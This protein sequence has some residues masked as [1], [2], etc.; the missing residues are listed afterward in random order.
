MTVAWNTPAI[1]RGARI[2]T[3]RSA[4]VHSGGI[5]GSTASETRVSTNTGF[6]IAGIQPMWLAQP[7]QH[8]KCRNPS[9][10]ELGAPREPGIRPPPTR[11]THRQE[12]R[13][14]KPSLAAGACRSHGGRT[15]SSPAKH[16]ATR[17]PDLGGIVL[18][19]LSGGPAGSRG[20]RLVPAERRRF[21]WVLAAKK[22]RH[23]RAR[24]HSRHRRIPTLRP[25]RAPQFRLKTSR[26]EPDRNAS[27]SSR[28]RP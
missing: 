22:L 1:M 13:R 2:M 10:R 11:Q 20:P 23:P 27:S 18:C 21:A 9:T 28:L 15:Q 6:R 24:R 4:E 19:A 14:T 12:M 7:Q 8:T 5:F 17:A 25:R 16:R 3:V 26:V